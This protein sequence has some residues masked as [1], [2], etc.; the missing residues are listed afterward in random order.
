MQKNCTT[1]FCD[2]ITSAENL[3]PGIIINVS[4]LV[5][6]KLVDEML[7]LGKSMITDTSLVKQ[8]IRY[9]VTHTKY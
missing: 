3:L 9:I 6:K 1:M 8:R 2:V 4:S 7:A 5:L